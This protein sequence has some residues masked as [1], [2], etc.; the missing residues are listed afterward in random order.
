MVVVIRNLTALCSPDACV[1]MLLGQATLCLCISTYAGAAMRSL[2]S[3]LLVMHLRF[4]IHS[5]Q[6]T[7][8]LRLQILAQLVQA[9]HP[10]V[11]SFVHLLV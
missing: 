2:L 6:H 5:P 8:Q 4:V 11:E 9:Y 7:C 1:E 10:L 3:A